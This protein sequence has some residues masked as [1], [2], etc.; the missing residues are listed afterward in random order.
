MSSPNEFQDM[1]SP[2]NYKDKWN[3][4]TSTMVDLDDAQLRWKGHY[5]SSL[6]VFILSSQDFAD[7][8]KKQQQVIHEF[9]TTE[10]DYMCDLL[11]VEKHLKSISLML[12]EEQIVSQF[13]ADISKIIILSKD[14]IR[15]IKERKSRDLG[16]ITHFGQILNGFVTG[17]KLYS[18]YCSFHP[19]VVSLITLQQ[20]KSREL[21]MIIQS[22]GSK[23]E[24]RG[25]DLFSFLLKPIQRICKYPLL[26]REVLKSTQSDS[27]EHDEIE[28]ALKD[29]NKIVKYINN[30]RADT[31]TAEK[32]QMIMSKL[33]VPPSLQLPERKRKYF[34]D[35]KL[36]L[37]HKSPV[38][39]F[40]ERLCVLLSD[41][42]IIAKPQGSDKFQILE[43]ISIWSISI[44]SK[45]PNGICDDCSFVMLIG[46]GGQ[47]EFLASSA[48]EKLL[49]IR[50]F[51]S[52]LITATNELGKNQC[53][54]SSSSANLLFDDKPSD[55]FK[56]QSLE[57]GEKPVLKSSSLFK[58][59]E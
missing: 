12:A 32:L 41:C 34:L 54:K 33:I 59:S 3:A 37:K 40:A 25:L 21:N 42:F 31:E 46:N 16:V 6:R 30:K 26:I 5:D 1:L 11:H 15:S 4:L 57:F 13:C 56:T 45:G 39:L 52:V 9:F 58:L 17:F 8:I 48:S 35:G 22:F 10:I 51:E 47:K 43:I 24:S 27:Q 23:T 28:K 20:K 18:T 44:A 50:N 2:A 49:W 14:L 36:Y 53:K 55:I 7:S 29:I 38:H 19:Q